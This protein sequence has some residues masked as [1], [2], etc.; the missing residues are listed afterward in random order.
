MRIS[1]DEDLY[2]EFETTATGDLNIST[3][4][5]DVSV[6]DDNMKVCSGKACPASVRSLKGTGN[7]VIENSVI[8]LGGIGVN[9]IDHQYILDVNGTLRAYGVTDASDRRLKKDVVL[10]TNY[11]NSR[12]FSSRL[13]L[14]PSQVPPQGQVSS[15]ISNLGMK[16]SL[17][18]PLR[19]EAAVPRG[20]I[21]NNLLKL[22][23]VTY[24]WKDTSLS[25]E[26]QI[27]LIAQEV[28]KLYPELVS[29]DEDGIKSVMY[30]KLTVI[31]LEAL[32]ELEKRVKE[33]EQ[34]K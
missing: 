9:T 19:A 7:L 24:K 23:G 3:V 34:D 5:G 28:E 8:A 17:E 31:L 6:L 15:E 16:S 10:L 27:G 21:L 20:E 12:D 1:Y 29:T 30:G 33:L 4:G 13:G 26:T 32:K 25:Q 14:F 22:R 18:E 11:L 2:S